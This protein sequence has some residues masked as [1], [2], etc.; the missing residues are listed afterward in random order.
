M[1][2]VAP[3]PVLISDLDL[4]AISVEYADMV[5][6]VDGIRRSFDRGG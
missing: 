5:I 6:E 4:T 1:G 3:P 2:R